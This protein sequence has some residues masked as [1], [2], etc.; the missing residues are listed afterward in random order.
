MCCHAL[1]QGILNQ[2]SNPSILCLLH[3][4]VVSLPLAS[5]T[6]IWTMVILYSFLLQIMC[7]VVSAYYLYF[8]FPFISY[9]SI[10][11]ILMVILKFSL[12]ITE[13]LW[14]C[15]WI[16][17]VI[18]ISINDYWNCVCHYFSERER[19]SPCIMDNTLFLDAIIE[20]LI[21]FMEIPTVWWLHLETGEPK[22]PTMLI[23]KNAFHLIIHHSSIWC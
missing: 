14:N 5:F 17:L 2:G 19:I 8:P 3:W 4:Q 1:L 6:E 15:N 22:G 7:I 16:W 18:N 20:L 21:C 13:N 11:N 23:N 9:I 10:D 12:Q